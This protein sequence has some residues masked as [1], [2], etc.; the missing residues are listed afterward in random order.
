MNA[1]KTPLNLEAQSLIKKGSKVISFDRTTENNET[2]K[3]V[4]S[5]KVL[6]TFS[7]KAAKKLSADAKIIDNTFSLLQRTLTYPDNFGP[8]SQ[9][10][11]FYS[12]YKNNV[13][14][15]LDDISLT[16]V[17]NADAKLKIQTLATLYRNTLL[18]LQHL[19]QEAKM[20]KLCYIMEK[21]VDKGIEKNAQEYRTYRNFKIMCLLVALLFTAIIALA[22][23]S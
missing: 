9:T 21:G 12:D 22:Q 10:F 20:P 18:E 8:S 2:R 11:D 17:G 4:F 5:G 7:A 19:S 1:Q 13:L 23:L 3:N 15:L 14:P 16:K 6:E